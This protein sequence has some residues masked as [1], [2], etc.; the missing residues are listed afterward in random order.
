MA[1]SSNGEEKFRSV[2]MA[3]AAIKSKVLRVPGGLQLLLA[4]GFSEHGAPDGD[5]E[6]VLKHG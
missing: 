4:A 1:L 3:N 5:A 2:R 6:R